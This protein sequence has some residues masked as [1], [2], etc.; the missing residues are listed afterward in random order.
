MFGNYVGLGKGS[1][2]GVLGFGRRGERMSNP[3][4]HVIYVTA[5]YIECQLA[6][7]IT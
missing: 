4:D 5:S 6:V 3:S 2:G 1:G 7:D